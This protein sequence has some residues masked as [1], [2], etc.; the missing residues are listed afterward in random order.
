MKDK[1]EKEKEKDKKKKR[2]YVYFLMLNFDSYTNPSVTSY[3]FS[4]SQAVLSHH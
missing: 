4:W 2:F 3:D 1:K